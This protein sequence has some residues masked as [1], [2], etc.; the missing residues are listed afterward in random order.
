MGLALIFGW[1]ME[2]DWG[3][4]VEQEQQVERSM[5]QDEDRDK[6]EDVFRSQESKTVEMKEQAQDPHKKDQRESKRVA[7][8]S[9]PVSSPPPSTIAKA[10]KDSERMRQPSPRVRSE[11]IPR[12]EVKK[13]RRLKA[14][15]PVAPAPKSAVVQKILED[16]QSVASAVGSPST[17]EEG[18]QQLSRSPFFADQVPKQ[19]EPSSLNAMELFY[20]NKGRRA[21]ET[22]EAIDD[23]RVQQLLGG[24]S[25][26]NEQV[27]QKDVSDL[28]ETQEAILEVFAEQTRGIRYSFVR[29]ILDGRTESVAITHYSG[30]WSELRLTIE[31]NVSGYLYVLASFGK[32]KWQYMRP[33]SLNKARSLDGGIQVMAYQSVD[34]EL[35]Q[36]ANRL[37]EPV[38]SSIVVLLSTELLTDLGKWL[39]N[40]KQSKFQFSKPG[41]Q[42]VFVVDARPKP[43]K[44]VWVKIPIV[45]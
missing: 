41:E 18:L 39:G 3:P 43:K 33:E 11:D 10:S 16:D 13:E 44:P 21:D 32:A 2:K 7:G 22:E 31:S 26:K 42:G 27:S 15:A 6:N 36:V 17:A 12:K 20:A 4:L 8:L 25:S 14:K 35:S 1:Q 5:S 23:M 45:N 28:K 38:V 30:K 37:G 34:F 9:A 29:E 24:M 19:D 40:A